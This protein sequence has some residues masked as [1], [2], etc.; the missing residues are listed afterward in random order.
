MQKK[1]LSTK[2]DLS[3]IEK[4]QPGKIPK[5]ITNFLIAA[6][7]PVL[8]IGCHKP[9]TNPNNLRD[10]QQVNLVANSAEYR[11]VT[12]D[13]TL[14]NAFGIA[15]SPNGIAWVNSVG[16]HVSELYNGEGAIVR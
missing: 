4:K 3:I 13:P 11:P 15:W 10:F 12:L 14:I 6:A 2:K 7:L 9:V 16:G 8:F 5:P 1:V